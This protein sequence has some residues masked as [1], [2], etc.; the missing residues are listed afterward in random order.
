ML[1]LRLMLACALLCGCTR[2]RRV[3]LRVQVCG[4]LCSDHSDSSRA[5]ND[6]TG[7]GCA[8][9]VRIRAVESYDPTQVAAQECI[10]L[11]NAGTQ[12]QDLFNDVLRPAPG[13]PAPL[14]DLPTIGRV[15]FEVALY[16]PLGPS[17][18]T[19]GSPF[20]AL[21]R[22]AIVDLAQPPDAI[23]VPLGCHEICD[24][25][26]SM[27]VSVWNLEDGQA[28]GSA[29]PTGST[30]VDI[31][32]YEALTSTAGSCTMPHLTMPRSETRTF[33]ATYIGGNRFMGA[34]GNDQGVY[35]GCLAVAI[36]GGVYTCVEPSSRQGFNV[37]VPS[38]TH[39]GELQ[40]LAAANSAGVNG[41][42]VVRVF[43][44]M[45]G[46]PADAH[47]FFDS[48]SG[49]PA[50]ADYV[51]GPVWSM[52]AGFATGVGS[53]GIAIFVDAPGG[54]Y[55]V[56]RGGGDRVYFHAAGAD[57]PSSIATYTLSLP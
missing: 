43:D 23:V 50:E 49:N 3:P 35:A 16:P 31:F 25:Q 46:T 54:P 21:G 11:R 10:D 4:Y 40:Q 13:R 12:F 6:F 9:S 34:F 33:P 55:Y 48:G 19:M 2:G 45:G 14:A 41:L 5:S 38:P 27:V 32:P 44:N 7:I 53:Q 29:L 22:S 51:S 1:P 18:C 47:V 37:W 30:L 39:I 56:Q 8:E 57:D 26:Q 17:P 24:I 52:L 20:V 28:A 42:L 36:P 15:A